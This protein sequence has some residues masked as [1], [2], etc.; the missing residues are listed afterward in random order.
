M[1]SEDT[2]KLLDILSKRPGDGTNGT[3]TSSLNGPRLAAVQD[4]GMRSEAVY[5]SEVLDRLEKIV[6]AD[7]DA[8]LQVEAIKAIA[9]ISNKQD[10]AGRLQKLL[11]NDREE[12]CE[13]VT[14][15]LA[16]L[17]PDGKDAV[18]AL[19]A[20]LGAA[21]NKPTVNNSLARAILVIER[22]ADDDKTE[23]PLL[24]EAFARLASSDPQ[25]RRAGV[26]FLRTNVGWHLLMRSK[27]KDNVQKLLRAFR[28]VSARDLL[29]DIIS[30]IVDVTPGFPELFRLFNIDIPP[31]IFE[32]NTEQPD[33]SSGSYIVPWKQAI[34][35]VDP[36]V[37]NFVNEKILKRKVWLEVK[38]DTYWYGSPNKSDPKEKPK[39]SK[40]E[41]VKIMDR[42]PHSNWFQIELQDGNNGWIDATTELNPIVFSLSDESRLEESSIGAILHCR[43][44]ILSLMLGELQD[45]DKDVCQS[46]IAWLRECDQYFI[47]KERVLVATA[48]WECVLQRGQGLRAY[49]AIDLR[50]EELV[51]WEAVEKLVY[52]NVDEKVV[53]GLLLKEAEREL[54]KLYE[55]DWSHKAR[56]MPFILGA[57]Q[58]TEEQVRQLALVWVYKKASLS[59]DNLPGPFMRDLLVRI[60]DLAVDSR[61]P[62]V[63]KAA[64]GA[65]VP[66]TQKQS[67]YLLGQLKEHDAL[68]IDLVQ[69]LVE[70]QS[71][72]VMSSL[73]R[74]WV[75]WIAEADKG[76]LVDATAEQLR[77]NKSA[78][79]PLVERLSDPLRF[80]DHGEVELKV[81]T[82]NQLVPIYADQL[83]DKYLL[84][85]KEREW[86]LEE[87]MRDQ[88]KKKDEAKNKAASSSNV[89]PPELKAPKLE[90]WIEALVDKGEKYSELD[91]TAKDNNWGLEKIHKEFAELFWRLEL[92]R[93]ELLA[94][95]RI[96]LQLAE[97]SSPRFFE[98]GEYKEGT[99]NPTYSGIK[100]ELR[101]HAV[102]Y[103]AHKLPEEPDLRVREHMART[104]ANVGELEAVDALALAIVAEDRTKA[105]RQ[106]VLAEYYLEPSKRRSEQAA[107][108]LTGAV[109]EAKHTMWLIQVL[110][111]ATFTLGVVI[112]AGGLYV[113]LSGRST[114]QFLGL[115]AAIGGIAG[116]IALLIKG[117]LNDIQNSVANLVQ[118]E[119]AFTNFIWE[120]NLNSTYIQSQYV[121]EGIIANDVVAATVD[122]MES[123]MST[124]LKVIA[125][126]TEEGR[127]QVFAHLN[128]LSPGSGAP[129]TE[130]KVFGQYLKK[131]DEGEKRDSKGKLVVGG[132]LMVEGKL[133][134]ALNHI[135]IDA[136]ITSWDKDQVTFKLP[137]GRLPG[138]EI[139]TGLIWISLI[140]YGVETN[141]VP[142]EVT[143]T[144]EGTKTADS[145][146]P[147][148]DQQ[149][150]P[151]K[152]EAQK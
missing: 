10:L 72:A 95:R 130:I 62:N 40:G 122:R 119:T 142:F 152:Q 56:I 76:Q 30:L 87:K 12:V 114:D 89:P 53:G 5:A 20:R 52:S 126:Y 77:N 102:P 15:A 44:N 7:E 43:Y 80:D 86:W 74:H 135:R 84:N 149:S 121:Q 99:G 71:P 45:R 92:E 31:I 112:V 37:R 50:D 134:V 63:Q 38:S 22:K 101:T 13:Q 104:L 108:I 140:V 58:S 90:E 68:A 117:P 111:V 54:D 79:L 41:K 100:S 27:D 1:A 144:V 33:H 69:E 4:L 94:R 78:V 39:V 14:S 65:L 123:A 133:M 35:L 19:W 42:S 23:H 103:L 128:S 120:L 21:A 132:K 96:A 17:G 48:L 109:G 64:R 3:A 139:E 6:L 51:M 115:F 9:A 110:S 25:D 73:I 88:E 106:E 11:A 129:G 29:V 60:Q 36:R 26:A 141:A 125:L 105:N 67:T 49:A 150:F 28:A 59:Q 124:A 70:M 66:I 127:E 148:L 146:N 24:A 85:P 147:K 107:K 118:L 143:K 137:A 136:D 47:P 81:K 61:Y 151:D 2:Y 34:F 116:I 145:E 91:Q 16:E 46:M 113:A 8:A 55:K 18:K 98:S 57:L 75:Y 138:L 82:L 131:V 93:R 97:M 32:P 83:L